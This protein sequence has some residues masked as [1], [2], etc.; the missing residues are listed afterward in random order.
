M[1]KKTQSVITKGPNGF[2]SK[3][4]LPSM[5]QKL[6]I[7]AEETAAAAIYA[8]NRNETNRNDASGMMAAASLEAIEALNL[9]DATVEIKQTVRANYVNRE[10]CMHAGNPDA[11]A[12]CFSETAFPKLRSGASLREAKDWKQLKDLKNSCSKLI[13]ACTRMKVV[14]PFYHLPAKRLN[15]M[16]EFDSICKTLIL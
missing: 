4:T 8:A 13:L 6:I 3:V 9:S 16:Q 14:N 7:D 11:F 1:N 2:Q 10:M 5:E 12:L 15:S